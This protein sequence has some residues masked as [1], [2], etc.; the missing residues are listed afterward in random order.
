MMILAPLTGLPIMVLRKMIQGKPLPDDPL[1]W[2]GEAATAGPGTPVDIFR[3]LNISPLSF[4]GGAF[5]PLVDIA[6]SR[7]KLKSLMSNLPLQS[8]YLNRLFPPKRK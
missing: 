2:Y 7:N 6:T 8:F 1:E 3:S 5:S 4:A